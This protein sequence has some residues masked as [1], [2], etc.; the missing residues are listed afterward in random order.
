MTDPGFERSTMEV[1]QE[2][3]TDKTPGRNGFISTLIGIK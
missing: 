1:F 3:G 2:M